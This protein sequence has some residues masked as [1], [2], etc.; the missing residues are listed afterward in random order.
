MSFFASYEIQQNLIRQQFYLDVE[1][2]V[3]Y[4]AIFN[5]IIFAFRSHLTGFFRALFTFI[6]NKVVKGDSLSADKAFSKSVW[7]LPAAC[8]AVAPTGMVHARTSF[9]PAV[10]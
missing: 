2:E 7:I 1:Q 10:K 9:T 6:G 4:I 8:G 3:H 5:D